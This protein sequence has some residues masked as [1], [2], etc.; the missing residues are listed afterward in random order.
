MRLSNHFRRAV[1][2]LALSGSMAVAQ[3]MQSPP[4]GPVHATPE[5]KTPTQLPTGVVP[6]HYR[7]HIKPDARNL[8]VSAEV[9]IELDVLK[10]TRTLTVHALDM[11]FDRAEISSFGIGQVKVDNMSQTA[12]FNFARVLP[13]GHHTLSIGYHGKIVQQASGLFALNYET[14]LGPR[15]A[16]FIQFEAADAR[17]FI[18][19]WEEPNFKA[20][21]ELFAT[22]PIDQLAVSNMPV[23]STA[24]A[25][26]GMKTV[27]FQTTPRMS[28]YLLSFNLG[29]FGRK[30][31]HV[32]TTEIGVVTRTGETA[33]AEFALKAARQSVTWYNDYFDI[34]FPL[35]K[36]DHIAARGQSPSFGA[37]ENWGAIFYFEYALLLDPDFSTQRNKQDIFSTVAH[38][39]AHPWFGNLVTMAWWDDLWLNEGFASWMAGHATVKFHPEWNAHL[40]TVTDREWAMR[41][42]AMATSHS[43]VQKVASVQQAEQAFDGITCQKG[44]AV[45]RMLEAYVGETA[46]RNGVR[47]YLKKHAYGNSVTRDLWRAVESAAGKPIRGIAHDFTRQPGVALISGLRCK[48]SLFL[49]LALRSTVLRSPKSRAGAGRPL[50]DTR[51]ESLRTRHRWWTS[52]SFRSMPLRLMAGEVSLLCIPGSS[53]SAGARRPTPVTTWSAGVLPRCCSA[54]TPRLTDSGTGQPLSF[55]LTTGEKTLNP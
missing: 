29:D 9:E 24:P 42:D 10:P 52:P 23:L 44:E 34:P 11:E 35:P 36:L 12:T 39:T 15:R 55:W 17:R 49:K 1:L 22:I 25:S 53:S 14:E 54:T 28:T 7:I 48:M 38:E 13:A 19:S 27:R 21:F 30:V 18:P 32:G 37:M 6:H 46:W 50:Q 5:R 4:V 26:E 45:I 16:L 41:K 51:P 33:K 8:R 3:S 43:V 47:S 31:K 20:T 2:A 40:E